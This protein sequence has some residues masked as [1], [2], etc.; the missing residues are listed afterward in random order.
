MY[1]SRLQKAEARLALADSKH[2]VADCTHCGSAR[3]YRLEQSG[4]FFFPF[5]ITR[6]IVFSS[7]LRSVV[8]FLTGFK[9]FPHCSF[10]KLCVEV[11]RK[12]A[13]CVAYRAV[14]AMD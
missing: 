9:L 12:F 7:S 5:F 14:L 6:K 8:K 10:S 3:T 1:A 2:K 11:A 4:F 13:T